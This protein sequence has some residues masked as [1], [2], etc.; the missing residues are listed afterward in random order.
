[1]VLKMK[2][3]I[4]ILTVSLLLAIAS[5]LLASDD[6]DK[7]KRLAD[8]GAIL[9]LEVILK[10]VREIQPGKVLE[11]ELE[12]KKGKMFYEI[13]ILGDNGNVFEIKFDAKTGKHISTEKEN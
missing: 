12:T 10:K 1:M 5:P 2:N 11:V 6:H 7:A 8:S 4:Q 3:K 9:G 13:E